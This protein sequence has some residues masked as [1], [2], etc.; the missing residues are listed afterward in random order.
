[1]DGGF[2]LPLSLSPSPKTPRG[3]MGILSYCEFFHSVHFSRTILA[4][5]PSVDLNIV[6]KGLGVRANRS[7]PTVL[8]SEPC[9]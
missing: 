9:L 2:F 1:M 3:N 6:Y 4:E 8:T 7:V 5:Y